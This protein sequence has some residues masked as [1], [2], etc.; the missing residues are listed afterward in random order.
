MIQPVGLQRSCVWLHP[1]HVSTTCGCKLECQG[2]IRLTKFPQP[3]YT[4][5]CHPM[6]AR[7]RDH[8]GKTWCLSQL[9]TSYHF[10][11]CHLQGILFH[12]VS[13]A[14]ELTLVL[15]CRE[16][17][18]NQPYCIEATPRLHLSDNCSQRGVCCNEFWARLLSAE[19]EK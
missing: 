10:W 3:I 11:I 13:R 12:V 8:T 5:S 18:P 6:V 19:V 7:C 4:S 15:G 17:C 14:A 16:V 9:P 1:E 2:F